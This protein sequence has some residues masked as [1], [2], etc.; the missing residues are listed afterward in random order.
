M[1]HGL[2]PLL[3]TRRFLPLF[4]TQFL[5]AMN[6]NLLKNALA[7]LIVYEIGAGAGAEPGVLVAIA[8]GLFIAPYFLFS[9]TAGQIA[10]RY[11]KSLLLRV[12]K[13]AEIPIMALAAV[14]LALADLHLLLAVL[15]L[16]GT[17]ATFFSPLKFAILPEHLREDELIGGNAL[18]E[19]GTFIGILVGTIAGGALVLGADGTRI[20]AGLGLALA[21][22]GFAASLAIPRASAGEPAVAVGWNLISETRSVIGT[23]FRDRRIFLCVLGLSWFWMM[24]ATFLAELPEFAKDVLGGNEHVVTLFLTLFSIGIAIGSWLCHRMLDGEVSAR[25]VPL[26]ALGMAL[27]AF[28][29]YFAIDGRVAPAALAGPLG[30]LSEPHNWRVAADFLLLAVCGGVYNVPL[31]AILQARSRPHERA[32]VVAGNNIVN[33][34]FMAV[35]AFATAAMIALGFGVVEVFLVIAT[36]S[37]AV[38]IYICGLLPDAALKPLFALALRLAY[39]VKVR[40]REHLK[41]AGSR[42]VIVA[43]HVSFLDAALLAT[44]LPGR[45]V[46]AIDTM[47]ARRWWVRPWLALV[48]A[49][50]VDPTRALSMRVFVDAVRAGRPV[51]IFPEGRLTVT[52]ALMK[53]YEGPGLIADKADAPIL[54]IRIDGAE[55]TIF[56]RLKGKLRRR[57]FP[58]IVLTILPPRR[59]EVPSELHGRRRRQKIGAALYDLMSEMVF[60][61]SNIDR[62]LFEALLNARIDHGGGKPIV[63]DIERRPL[64]YNR[65]IIGS[66][67][68]GR[69]LNEIAAPREVVAMMLPNSAGAA[70]VFFALIATGRIPAML[71]YTAG[72]QGMLAACTAADVKTVVTA[73]RFVELARLDQAVAALAANVRVVYLE[74]VRASIGFVERLAGYLR[75][76]I[77]RRIHRRSGIKP[78]DPAVILFTSGSEGTPKGVVLS[79]RNL[80]ANC[81]QIASRVAFNPTDIAFN[82]LPVFHSFGLTG[83]LILPIVAGVK[84]FLYPS[85]LHYRIVSELVYDT[86]ASVLFGTDTFLAGYARV[87][88][89][90]DFYNVRYVFA[91]A[92]KVREETRRA[93]MERFGLRILEGYGVTETAPVLATN[94]PMQFKAGTVG[95][96]LPGVRHR[97]EKVPG[98]DE[99]GRLYV[100]GPN[101]MRGYLRHDRPGAVETLDEGWHDTGDIVSIDDEGYVRIVG[102]VKRF[103]KIG[104]EMVSLGAVEAVFAAEWPESVH[105]VVAVPDPRKGEQLVL[106]TTRAGTTRDDA[107]HVVRQRGLPELAAPR[108]VIIVATMP[109]LGTGKTDYGAVRNLI[110]EQIAAA[111]SA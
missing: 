70:V 95:R 71:N 48:E 63:E 65:L 109:L 5:G 108:Q 30:F 26:A 3:R 64:T 23:T 73:R 110:D 34:F 29:L 103:A 60:E 66:L 57:W 56:S 68:L 52:G 96:F 32:R 74:D 76:V 107:G 78:D 18:I 31:Y 47:M 4:V 79:H 88:H 20:V 104:G 11:E 62:T 24:G 94:T 10:D 7:I 1:V 87:A 83:G 58:R 39:G 91:G 50:P 28:D 82:A 106:V 105:A 2:L 69:R 92:E 13:F 45:P 102:R 81:H 75:R 36:G 99:G 42:V 6:D 12:I 14:G 22:A 16:L 55:H 61:T 54:P 53:V 46:F 100:A 89:S 90:Y 101:V 19:A 49:L 86:N 59:F 43:N 72:A 67:V 37:L 21:T 9:A 40:G 84:T 77:A 8:A 44:F 33:A 111:V 97:L 35:A 17:Q 15:F 41:T 85:P 38:A 51:V 27:F 98:I 93:W 25:H 80:L